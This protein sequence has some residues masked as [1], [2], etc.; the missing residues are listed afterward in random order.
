MFY[1]SLIRSVI[2][3][4]YCANSGFKAPALSDNPFLKY[5]SVLHPDPPAPVY[6]KPPKATLESSRPPAYLPLRARTLM[7]AR[8]CKSAGQARKKRMSCVPKVEDV[9]VPRSSA[10]GDSHG[11]EPSAKRNRRIHLSEYQLQCLED[12][13]QNDPDIAIIKIQ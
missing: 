13:L 4:L 9:A 8:V 3:Q 5:L 12:E 11:Q 2:F 10:S 1:K 7:S 6:S